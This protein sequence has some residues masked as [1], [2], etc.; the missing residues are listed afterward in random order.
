MLFCASGSASPVTTR[1]ASG[2]T[3][4]LTIY[5]DGAATVLPIGTVNVYTNP[6]DAVQLPRVQ[7]TIIDEYEFWPRD[8]SADPEMLCENG[9]DGKWNPAT[10]V[11][12]L[13]AN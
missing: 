5:V 3:R 8:L 10:G 2:A 12:L 9:W 6:S 13:T 1:G 7:G 11:C 4:S